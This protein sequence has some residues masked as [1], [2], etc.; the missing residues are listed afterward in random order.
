MEN[1]IFKPTKSGTIQ[2][3]TTSPL[4]ACIALHGLESYL[5]ETMAGEIIS[6]RK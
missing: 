2:E 5:K 4:L 3:G 6:Y 1:R